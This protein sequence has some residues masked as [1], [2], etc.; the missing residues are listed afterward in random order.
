M[1]SPRAYNRRVGLCVL[2][3]ITTAVKGYPFECLIPTGS[4]ISGAVLS[5]QIK[6]MSWGERRSAFAEKAP[7]RLV[8]DVRAKIKAL[9]DIR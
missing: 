9:L 4:S 8:A 7:A 1:L 6:S 2:C 3:P 5:D